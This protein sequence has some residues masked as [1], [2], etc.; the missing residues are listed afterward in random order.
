VSAL[1]LEVK[2]ANAPE[3]PPLYGTTLD[4]AGVRNAQVRLAL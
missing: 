2:L 4:D 3:E 1:P